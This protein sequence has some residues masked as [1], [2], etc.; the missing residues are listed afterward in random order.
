MLGMRERVSSRKHFGWRQV[1][2][3]GERIIDLQPDS[4]ERSFPPFVARND[5]REVM[6][7]MRSV[8]VEQTTFPQGLQNQ[9]D[10]SLFEITNSAVHKLCAAT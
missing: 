7:K 4:E 1:Q 10:I 6:N 2:A 5:E 9:R 3:A 8:A